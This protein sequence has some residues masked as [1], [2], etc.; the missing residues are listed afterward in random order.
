MFSR[1]FCPQRLSDSHSPAKFSESGAQEP[2]KGGGL[3]QRGFLQNAG[4][5]SKDTGPQSTFGTESAAAK[6]GTNDTDMSTIQNKFLAE[7]NFV[8][9]DKYG[10][11]VEECPLP[12]IP[13][14]TPSLGWRHS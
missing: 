3:Q 9:A 13:K 5:A 4:V 12:Q 14:G 1:K 2:R 6:M 8:K 7:T 10:C 11:N